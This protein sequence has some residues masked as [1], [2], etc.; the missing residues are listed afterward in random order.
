[1]SKNLQLQKER[2][3]QDLHAVIADSEALLQSG[4]H[5]AEDSLSEAR[6]QIQDRL[7]N[8]KANLKHLQDLAIQ[9]AEA[10][11]QVADH[12]VHAHPWQAIGLAGGLGLLLGV[13]MVRR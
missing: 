10:A 6:V 1:M 9:R 13:L 4:T 8:A 2:L 5:D 7:S 3:M 11:G 12:Y